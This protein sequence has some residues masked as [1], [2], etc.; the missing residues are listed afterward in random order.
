MDDRIYKQKTLV[1]LY[2]A[3][4]QF[5]FSKSCDRCHTYWNN[6]DRDSILSHP[7]TRSVWCNIEY[8]RTCRDFQ[9]E[10]KILCSRSKIS[11]N[12]T[13]PHT[14]DNPKQWHSIYHIIVYCAWPNVVSANMR[15]SN[16]LLANSVHVLTLQVIIKLLTR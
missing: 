7:R 5:S 11:G 4:Q 12:S 16:K 6:N 9:S 1:R 8:Y 2:F 15:L 13:F 14:I 3:Y 10:R